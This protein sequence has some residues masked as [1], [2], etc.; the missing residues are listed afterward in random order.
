MGSDGERDSRRAALMRAAAGLA[1]KL[2]WRS[3]VVPGP[4]ARPILRAANDLLFVS[5]EA[6]EWGWRSLVATPMFLAQCA[7]HG[8][9]VSVDRIP[10]MHGSCR[11]EL[12]SQVRV[13]G[14]I[15]ILG[16]RNRSPL[17]RIG[18]GVF[19]GHD[20]TFAVAERIEIGNWVSI[21]GR[22]FIAD[23][24]GHSH[25]LLDVPIWEDRA[26]EDD[27]APVIIEDNVH[28]GQLCVILKGVRIGARSIIGAGAVVRSD[29]PPDSIVAGN[30][31]RVAGW[32]PGTGPS[33]PHP[34]KNGSG[35]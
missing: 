8:D 2:V 31:A 25:R 1:R 35:G 22:T 9:E 6:Y 34:G 13:S 7:S 29:V 10:Y 27:I 21:G 20:V 16:A 28:I 18:S 4:V 19:I 30:P 26:G 24:T 14:L 3:A 32:R 17:L 5:R 11:M 12:G 15:S 23:T 33:S